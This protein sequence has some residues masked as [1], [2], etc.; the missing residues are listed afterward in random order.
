MLPVTLLILGLYGWLF[1]NRRNVLEGFAPK[2]SLD[3]ILVPRSQGIFWMK[4]FS[5]CASWICA[6]L[7]L[8]QPVGN[9]H[10]PEGGMS[11]ISQKSE[12]NQKL[13]VR[14]KAHDVI[15]LVDASS[16]M[17]VQ[18][19]RLGKTRL[20]Y[21][22][23]I[24][25]ALIGSLTGETASLYAFT[26]TTTELSPSTMDYLYVR[27]MLK[28]M[29]I[30]EGD[31]AGTN[32]VDALSEIRKK[33]L[34][35]PSP[36]SKTLILL[37]DGGDTS[38]ESLEG[39]ARERAIDSVA[40]LLGNAEAL[41]LRV[42]TIGVG[43]RTGQVIPGTEYKGQPVESRV[44]EDI[45]SRIATIGRGEYYYANNYTPFELSAEIQRVMNQ[46]PQYSKEEQTGMLQSLISNSGLVYDRY[47]QIPLGLAIFFLSFVLLCPDVARKE[48]FA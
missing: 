25:D 32:I 16:S 10:Y 33:Y 23:D 29:H 47:F 43:S 36:K 40:H 24:A 17:S 3:E 34:S 13:E 20:E 45:L 46:D 19:A 26:S 48:S 28:Q 37:T 5:L 41:Q 14:R 2:S 44:Q 30:N 18:D 42:F 12:P 8:M 7:A 11:H 35:A 38:I 39:E 6:V 1:V 4:V 21:A 31:V 27:L 9:G 22:K 15:F